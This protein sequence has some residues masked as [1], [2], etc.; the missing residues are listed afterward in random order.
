MRKKVGVGGVLVVAI[1]SLVW[2]LGHRNA[3]IME[4]SAKTSNNSTS[5]AVTT[6]TAIERIKTPSKKPLKKPPPI[7][8]LPFTAD[9][10]SIDGEADELSQAP[11]A[12]EVMARMALMQKEIGDNFFKIAPLAFDELMDE[13]PV[14]HMWTGIVKANIEQ[15]IASGEIGGSILELAQCHQTLCK[16][17]ISHDNKTTRRK[18]EGEVL[19]DERLLGPYQAFS[20]VNDDGSVDSKIYMGKY[21][22]DY[23]LME[24]GLTRAYE[25]V[26]GE[27]ADSIVPTENQIA[28]VEAQ[29][30]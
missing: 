9:T 18:F 12:P 21:G 5:A 14:N 24:A 15:R 30:K 11:V 2:F 29:M 25:M 28:Q 6:V 27:S 17:V 13:E 3:V 8:P 20:H 4:P 16:I 23:E 22:K 7:I 19:G 26:T 1:I 10:A